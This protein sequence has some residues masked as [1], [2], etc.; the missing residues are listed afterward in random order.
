MKRRNLRI[1]AVAGALLANLA[2]TG[3]V[4]PVNSHA[5]CEAPD[6][7]P[8]YVENC[9]WTFSFKPPTHFHWYC[10]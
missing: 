2:W 3:N 4:P 1:V 7:G 5:G 8:C 6:G 9:T 10:R